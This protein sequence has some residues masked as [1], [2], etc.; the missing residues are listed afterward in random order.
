[1]TTTEEIKLIRSNLKKNLR[2]KQKKG[3][4]SNE[5]M[6]RNNIVS[7]SIHKYINFFKYNIQGTN[8]SLFELRNFV[9]EKYLK[10]M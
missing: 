10:K 9:A 4:G 8:P 6:P 1:M 5:N 3:Y 2:S 7:L